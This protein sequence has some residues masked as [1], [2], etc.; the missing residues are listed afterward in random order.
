[1][2]TLSDYRDRPH[3][4]FSAL[5]QFFNICSL[6]YAFDKIYRLPK[7]FTPLP[8][9]FGSAYHRVMEWAALTRMQG[10]VPGAEDASDL[11][12]TLWG[13][14]L[15]EDANIK[16]DDGEDR[17][18]CARQG[19]DMCACA[20]AGTDPEEQVISVSEAFC[21]PLTDAAGVSM[22]TPLIG[23]IDCAV[24]K[25]GVKT[26]VDWKTASKRWSKDKA[27]RD[28]QPTAFINGYRLKHGLTPEF[29]FDVCVKN[30]TPVMERHVTTR[31]ADDFVR[32]AEYARLAE[33]MIAAEHFAPSEQG[34]YCNGCPHQE[35]CRAWHR[36]R[37]R[38]CVRLAA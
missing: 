30:K 4:S 16:Y 21:V 12:Q 25:G 5:N 27:A 26:L 17:D 35:P 36:N 38:A 22:E 10:Q 3:W 19:R 28:W 7:A 20:V 1:M 31:T 14:Q 23:E 15:E 9:S 13:R 11:F 37:A 34:F 29:R 8:L 18:T 6:Q 33:S 32:L 2:G 24:E